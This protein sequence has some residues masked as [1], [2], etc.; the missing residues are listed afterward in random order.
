MEKKRGG[1]GALQTN[2]P[3]MTETWRKKFDDED[4]AKR[5]VADH[6]ARSPDFDCWIEKVGST[7]SARGKAKWVVKR[8]LR[9]Q[10]K[11][12]NPKE[13]PRQG[14]FKCVPKIPTIGSL[15]KFL[16]SIPDDDKH[17]ATMLACAK[18]DEGNSFQM[19]LNET[20]T[21]F[22]AVQQES[23]YNLQLKTLVPGGP[24]PE[25]TLPVLVIN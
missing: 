15:R 7:R 1:E 18:D 16:A 5:N 21:F 8:K 14:P 19:V 22:Q 25:G 10:L 3:R 13:L 12:K 9:V 23:P 24:D 6:A 11:K 2:Q 4:S 17:N 20:P